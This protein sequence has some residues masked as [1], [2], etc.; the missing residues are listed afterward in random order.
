MKTATASSTTT[1]TATNAQLFIH[2]ASALTTALTTALSGALAEATTLMT[3]E[4]CDL[5]GG[6]FPAA[7]AAHLKSIHDRLHHGYSVAA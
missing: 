2:P 3:C 4:I 7:E 6:P 1:N 5:T